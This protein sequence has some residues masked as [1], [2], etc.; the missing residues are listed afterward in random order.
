MVEFD[1]VKRSWRLKKCPFFNFVVLL[2]L[3]LHTQAYT[4]KHAH[5]C[6]CASKPMTHHRESPWSLATKLLVGFDTFEMVELK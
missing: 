3:Y 2:F 4:H 6:I 1:S 5:T